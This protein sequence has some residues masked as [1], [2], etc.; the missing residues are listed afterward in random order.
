M[1][2]VLIVGLG[3]VGAHLLEFLAIG[4]KCPH[5]VVC[6]VNE[7]ICP[8][9]VNNALIGGA[10]AG[11]YPTITFKE[12]DL[13]DVKGAT[14]LIKDVGP[15][16][17]VNST[18]IRTWHVIRKLLQDVYAKL[19]SA[20]LDACLPANWRPLLSEGLL[21]ATEPAQKAPQPEL[22]TSCLI[23]VCEWR[24]NNDRSGK[25]L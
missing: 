24:W 12:L 7:D 6:D 21:S 15:E 19:A 18:V 20:D 2:K 22:H 11:P 25:S 23:N 10:A 13:A 3:N 9:R 14:Q 4:P 17:V 8:K 1:A 16:V 5:L